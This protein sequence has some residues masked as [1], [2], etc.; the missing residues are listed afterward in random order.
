MVSDRGSNSPAAPPAPAPLAE[1]ELA[2]LRARVAPGQEYWPS[3]QTDL[4][5]NEV[6][7]LFATIDADRRRIAELTAERDVAHNSNRSME[8]NLRSTIK[9]AERFREERN[10]A[11]AEAD[12]LR[13]AAQHA[14]TL[15]GEITGFLNGLACKDQDASQEVQDRHDAI[16]D[17]IHDGVVAMTR[18]ALEAALDIRVTE[19]YASAAASP[20]R[21][22]PTYADMLAFDS[23]RQENHCTNTVCAYQDG[24]ACWAEFCE[25]RRVVWA[26][27]AEVLRLRKTLTEEQA[28]HERHDKALSKSGRKDTEALW[29]RGQ[30]RERAEA[31]RAALVAADEDAIRA[32]A[33][34]ASG[35]AGGERVD[36]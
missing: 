29:Q 30:H 31:I 19:S 9:M 34:L 8:V 6:N 21:L 2:K 28:W 35:A 10:A 4:H 33:A 32:R 7:A 36:G 5:T 22:G 25:R 18:N 15:L 24:C 3:G 13:D 27:A 23:I 26:P 12:A 14:F 11:C 17:F 20:V 16:H 1:A